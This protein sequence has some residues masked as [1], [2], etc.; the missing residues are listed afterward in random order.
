MCVRAVFDTR[1]TELR[2]FADKERQAASG[3]HAIQE[4]EAGF[5]VR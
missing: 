5:E 3:G 1:L 2:E 4:L